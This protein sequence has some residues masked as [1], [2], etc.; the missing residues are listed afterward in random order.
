MKTP[1]IL[2]A[3]LVATTAQA[4][5]SDWEWDEEFASRHWRTATLNWASDV[6]PNHPSHATI[7]AT[8]APTPEEMWCHGP[9]SPTPD[10]L[11][12]WKDLK[13]E[14]LRDFL[15]LGPNDPIPGGLPPFPKEC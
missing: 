2:T 11:D 4:G 13:D 5:G 12:I 9:P 6:H 10:D 1:L 3:L 15:D 7:I 8:M 14:W